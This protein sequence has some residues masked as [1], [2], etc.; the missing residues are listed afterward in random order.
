MLSFFKVLL[1][2]HVVMNLVQGQGPRV[3]AV[4]ATK[5][6]RYQTRWSGR[7]V[8]SQ[9][10][11]ASGSH[12]AA[13]I[14][15]RDTWTIKFQCPFHS[16]SSFLFVFPAVCGP[17]QLTLTPRCVSTTLRYIREMQVQLAHHW[18]WGEIRSLT[19]P[20]TGGGSPSSLT[21]R[22]R[23]SFPKWELPAK[24][25]WWLLLIMPLRITEIF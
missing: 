11:K 13:W 5:S 4:L 17:Q 3:V 2:W 19:S 25:S 10:G 14:M 21:Y 7:Y 18:Y 8:R 22:M 24:G 23:G 15:R 20:H 6:S 12:A 9:Q 16:L 1:L